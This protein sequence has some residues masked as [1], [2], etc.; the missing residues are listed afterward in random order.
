MIL[1]LTTGEQIRINLEKTLNLALLW[2]KQNIVSTK[3]QE[4][5]VL[6][7]NP[8]ITKNRKLTLI[9]IHNIL[10]EN[11]TI[12]KSGVIKHIDFLLMVNALD[13]EFI[14]TEK[15]REREY[16]LTETG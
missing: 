15:G 11:D 6:F 12:T 2:V 9:E 7:V 1:Q 3:K 14:K 5:L 16:T 8:K 4:I 13:G 10:N